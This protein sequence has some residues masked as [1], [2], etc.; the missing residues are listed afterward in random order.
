MAK[1]RGL[2]K[3]SDWNRDVAIQSSYELSPEPYRHPVRRDYARLIHSPSFRRLQGKTQLFPS[4]ENDFFRNRLSHSLEVAQ[5]AKSIC[6]RLN[7]IVA[8]FTK[9]PINPDLVEFAALAHDLGHPPFGHNGEHAL[10]DLMKNDGGFE[11]NAQTLRILTRLEKKETLLFPSKNADP[12][13]IIKGI[14]QRKGLNL[15][16]RSI[17]SVLKYDRVI[18]K[19]IQTRKKTGQY[20]NPCKGYYY[21]EAEIVRA[22]K[23][24]VVGKGVKNFRTIE[25]SIMDIADDIAYSTYDIEDSFKAG[26]LSPIR[27][28]SSPDI[29]K[30]RLVKTVERRIETYYSDKSEG[31]KRFSIN[32]LNNILGTIFSKL[33]DV[34]DRNT[35]R[36][37]KSSIDIIE[38]AYILSTKVVDASTEVRSNG[39]FRTTFTSELVGQFIR[40]VEV[41]PN[42]ECPQLSRARLDIDTFK[43]VETLKAF[44]YENLIE[45]PRLRLAEQRGREI[46]SKLFDA[47]I[48]RPALLPEDWRVL[49]DGARGDRPWVRRVICD[50][51]AGMTDRYCVEMYGRL[52]GTDPATIYKPH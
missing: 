12:S 29:L 40:G 33:L 9:D 32:D 7:G 23:E 17:A 48:K 20:N 6:L 3:R 1:I 49:V 25:C 52:V 44:A 14:D 16:Y 27:M 5:V 45:S 21:T 41:I 37:L 47:F 30:N 43:I 39:Y 22:V 36:R 26:F 31:D 28:M 18:P 2:Y 42:I 34:A 51:I 8:P 46:I 4:H 10:D 11:G 19:T 13:P 24:N 35:L 38:L 15:T 50:Y